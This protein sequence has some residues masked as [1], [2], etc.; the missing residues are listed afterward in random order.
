MKKLTLL[1]LC[2]VLNVLPAAAWQTARIE[3]PNSIV[4]Y[5]PSYED[6]LINDDVEDDDDDDDKTRTQI[7]ATTDLR[8]LSVSSQ[9]KAPV[10]WTD[11]PKAGIPNWPFISSIAFSYLNKDSVMDADLNDD[12]DAIKGEMIKDI[13]AVNWKTGYNISARDMSVWKRIKFVCGRLTAAATADMQISAP[14]F[15]AQE[16]E[17]GLN[18]F[19]SKVLNSMQCYIFDQKMKHEVRY[20]PEGLYWEIITNKPF[21]LLTINGEVYKV[22]ETVE[23]NLIEQYGRTSKDRLL[24]VLVKNMSKFFD[25]R[26]KFQLM[27]RDFSS[28]TNDIRKM[29][30]YGDGDAW[31]TWNLLADH[32]FRMNL[33]LNEEHALSTDYEEGT[34]LSLRKNLMQIGQEVTKH[35]SQK[36][37]IRKDPKY[38]EMVKRVDEN[39]SHV[40][41]L[42]QEAAQEL[43]DASD[44]DREI[45][46][47]VY[48]KN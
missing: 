15:S 36:D 35:I 45:L 14:G 41:N 6:L 11:N 7:N 48:K 40:R 19:S 34:L 20:T 27:N 46:L 47:R 12:F 17:E 8:D 42:K 29:A 28:N 44:A 23:N 38:A 22:L 43:K 32:T 2:A 13:K 10:R 31:S 9:L 37:A 16:I 5:A 3:G 39:Y 26:A 1:L 18:D 25:Y 24:G 4:I 21:L 30:K 33:L